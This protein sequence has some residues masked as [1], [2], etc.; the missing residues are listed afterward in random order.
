[1]SEPIQPQPAPAQAGTQIYYTKS[2]YFR[3]IHVDGMYGG[4]APAL[5]S[6]TMTVFSGR[7]PLP[8]KATNDA[9]GNEIVKE[10]VAKYGIENELECTLVMNLETAKIM[11][12]WLEGAINRTEAIQQGRP[13]K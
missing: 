7:T 6:M 9:S 13:W 4:P 11:L 10:R 1:M 2:N 3:V 12:K 8:E 5:G